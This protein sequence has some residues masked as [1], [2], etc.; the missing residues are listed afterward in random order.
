M[1]CLVR[2]ILVAV[3]AEWVLLASWVVWI[4]T[5]VTGESSRAL[6]RSMVRYS[7]EC[8]CSLTCHLLPH[9]WWVEI[10]QACL[11]KHYSCATK[12]LF[13]YFL[14]FPIPYHLLF[15]TTLFGI[16]SLGLLF[17][18][19]CTWL[20][21]LPCWTVSSFAFSFFQFNPLP[22]PCTHISTAVNM[23]VIFFALPVTSQLWCSLLSHS[24]LSSAHILLLQSPLRILFPCLSPCLSPLHILSWYL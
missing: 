21:P 14:W 12:A 20:L 18:Y 9:P 7:F 23:L 17:C 8:F 2:L 1:K 3:M 13:T 4:Q 5:V 22:Y 11:V 19:C 16:I 15:P 10:V 24:I 6:P